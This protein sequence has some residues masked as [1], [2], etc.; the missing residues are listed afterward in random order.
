MVGGGGGAGARCLY[1]PGR[2]GLSGVHQDPQI[3]AEH[4]GKGVDVRA[5]SHCDLLDDA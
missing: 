4:L 2:A 3:S 1:T 5:D